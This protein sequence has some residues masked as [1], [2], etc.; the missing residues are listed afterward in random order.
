LIEK[1]KAQLAKEAGREKR[2]RRKARSPITLIPGTG[3]PY[4]R[5][6]RVVIDDGL[7][8]PRLLRASPHS[9]DYAEIRRSFDEE[10]VPHDVGDPAAIAEA[11]EESAYTSSPSSA[12]SG[13][14]E[15]VPREEQERQTRATRAKREKVVMS[16]LYAID[17]E[18]EKIEG[19]GH[20]KPSK[21]RFIRKLLNQLG[22]DAMRGAGE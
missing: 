22:E 16:P 12:L 17:K 18:L 2:P 3:K 5:K 19:A 15:A 10:G 4:Q 8:A 7:D 9:A 1:S 14:P 6:R 13:E 11:G 21:V 20:Y